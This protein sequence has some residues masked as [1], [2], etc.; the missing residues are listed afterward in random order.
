MALAVTALAA[1]A[2]SPR[3]IVG[4][5]VVAAAVLSSSS[6][7]TT[8][9]AS[10]QPWTVVSQDGAGVAVETLSVTVP[11]G[12]T[13]TL[14]RFDA[15]RVAFDL[16]IGSTDPPAD[17]ST[18]RPDRGPAVGSGESRVLL[19]A[20]NGGFKMNAHQGGVE[21]D[22]QVVAPLA[23]GEASLVIDADGAAHVG[24]WGRDLPTLGERVESVRQNLPP[25]IEH[26]VISPT[27]SVPSDWGATVGGTTVVA[28]SAA[29]EDAQGNIVYAA[30]MALLPEDLAT[31]LVDVGVVDAMQLD[32][33]PTWV[34][35]DAA[36]SPGGPLHALVPGQN[37]PTTQFLS[38][39]TR[40]FFAVLGFI[41]VNPA[42]P[43]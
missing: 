25:L 22:G 30:G 43:R 42:R 31:A 20:F 7:T 8:V 28:R 32:I 18:I 17:L 9:P 12:R 34:Q 39:W 40:D 13:V 36:P 37:R 16:H 11:S 4:A 29:G 3:A 5:P 26:G 1:S 38:G 27:A 41:R 35:A 33:N 14:L 23:D 6:S 2:S 15:G 19:G 21:V 24:V 10:T